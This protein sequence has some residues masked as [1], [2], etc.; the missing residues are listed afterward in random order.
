MGQQLPDPLAL[1]AVQQPRGVGGAAELGEQVG[2]EQRVA[3][4]A[5]GDAADVVPG[6]AQRGDDGRPA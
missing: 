3:V 2:V 1:G 6:R 5:G 4:L